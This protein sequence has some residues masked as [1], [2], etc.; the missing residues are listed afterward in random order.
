MQKANTRSGFSSFVVLL[1]LALKYICGDRHMHEVGN[2]RQ[3]SHVETGAETE[4]N[5]GTRQ[6]KTH[7]VR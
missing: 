4:R 3:F 6:Q 2:D 5:H 7:T 1:M